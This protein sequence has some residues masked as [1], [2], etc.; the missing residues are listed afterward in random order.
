MDDV[1]LDVHMGVKGWRTR[2][3]D[4]IEWASVVRV[5]RD[6]LKG[7][8]VLKKKKKQKKKKKKKDVDGSVVVYFWCHSGVSLD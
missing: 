5:A 7:V 6:K 4:R 1:E 8:A 2:V 3:V